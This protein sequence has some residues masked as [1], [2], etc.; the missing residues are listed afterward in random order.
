MFRPADAKGDLRS[1]GMTRIFPALVLTALLSSAFALESRASDNPPESPIRN[2]FEQMANAFSALNY[3]GTFVYSHGDSMETLRIV[4]SRDGDIERER[5]VRL[6]GPRLELIREGDKISC[7]HPADWDGDINHRIPV[8]PFAKAFIRDFS[9]LNH[10]YEFQNLGEDRIVGR[11]AVK[12]SIKPVD[13]L[14]Y[15]YRVWIDKETGLLL[16]SLLLHKGKVL[17]RFQ[18]TQLSLDEKIPDEELVVGIEGDVLVHYPVV[19]GSDPVVPTVSAWKLEWIPTGFRMSLQGIRRNGSESP[20]ADTLTY[21]DG[22]SAFSVF[23]ESLE[24]SPDDIVE[25]ATT[26]KGATVAVGRVVSVKDHKHLVTVV[27]EVP[28][29]TARRLA[30]S[31]VPANSLR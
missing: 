9:E 29:T 30:A 16:K 28:L 15:G 27:G 22:M 10:S 14:R 12:V 6:D 4:H 19:S 5:I 8:G 3:D 20:A 26:Q 13:D 24:K 31:V 2:L 11:D 7:L 21:S 23:V 25:E 17:E 18:F 1:P